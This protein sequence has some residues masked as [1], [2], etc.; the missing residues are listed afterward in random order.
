VFHVGAILVQLT[1]QLHQRMKLKR[2]DGGNCR[3]D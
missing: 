3:T 1:T 2:F